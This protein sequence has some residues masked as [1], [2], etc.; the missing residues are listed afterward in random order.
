MTPKLNVPVQKTIV[1]DKIK[2]RKLC[3]HFWEKDV[4]S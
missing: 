1:T 2:C 4:K 3:L